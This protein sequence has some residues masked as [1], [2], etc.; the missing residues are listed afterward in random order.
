MGSQGS[1]ASLPGPLASGPGPQTPL[2]LT[3]LCLLP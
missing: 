3:A 1:K 2:V